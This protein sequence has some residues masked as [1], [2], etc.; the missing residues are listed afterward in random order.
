M[1][2]LFTMAAI[3]VLSA[4]ANAGFDVMTNEDKVVAVLQSKDLTDAKQNDGYLASLPLKEI[5]VDNNKVYLTYSAG[6][7][8]CSV[9][10][11]IKGVNTVPDSAAGVNIVAQVAKLIVA[12]AMD[13]N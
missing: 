10:A 3:C 7:A 5:S 6:S 11:E 8:P 2:K 12:C 9:L 4:T 1:T 13:Q